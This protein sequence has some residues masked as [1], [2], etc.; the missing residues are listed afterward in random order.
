MLRLEQV[1]IDGVAEAL[2]DHS[3]WA[4]WWLDPDTGQVEPWSND[5]GL[6]VRVEHPEE[7]GLAF[8][9]PGSSHESYQDMADFTERVRD[10]RARDLLDRAITGRGA[11]RRFKDTLFEFPELREVWF[12]FHKA[13]TRRRAVDWLV[14]TGHL[15]PAEA[16]AGRRADADP[17]S[18]LLGRGL[19]ADAIAR[20]VAA[21]LRELYGER[22]RAVLLFGSYA[23]G[24]ADEESDIDLL[25]VL[26]EVASVYDELTA[27]DDVMWRHTYDNDV[28]VS[29]VAV[30]EARYLAAATPFLSNVAGEG[31]L[32]S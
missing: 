29:A 16:A 7:R 21:D 28:A 6:D 4:S 2:E 3:D 15:D 12:A 27:M 17:P 24:T 10:P 18:A 1:D 32:V 30:S 19:D 25:V 5:I 8:I 20:S 13:R 23:R 31:R 22:L 14:D 9:Q 26:D 11:F